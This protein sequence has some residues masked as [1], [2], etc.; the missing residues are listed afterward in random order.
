[1]VVIKLIEGLPVLSHPRATNDQTYIGI[2]KTIYIYI[3]IFVRSG[4]D[5]WEWILNIYEVSIW[6]I[7]VGLW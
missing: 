7:G 1:M 6:Y 2:F 5:R 4:F 3:Y